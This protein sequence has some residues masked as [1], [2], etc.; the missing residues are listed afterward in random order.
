MTKITTKAFW[1]TSGN[2]GSRFLNFLATIYLA[3][4]LGTTN[5]GLISI[6]LSVLGYAVWISDMGLVKIGTRETAKPLEKREFTPSALFWIR[7]GA[8][9][10]VFLGGITLVTVLPLEG[11][12]PLVIGLFL[13]SVIPQSLFLDWYFTGLQKY[14]EVAI[15]KILKSAFFF[16]LV[17]LVIDVSQ[18]VGWV[19]LFY[20]AGSLT[21]TTYLFFRLQN[22]GSI[23]R[24]K[25]TRE[26]AVAAIRKSLTI[27]FGSS[28]NQVVQ[29]LPPIVIGA[30]ISAS[31]AGIYSAAIKVVL[32]GS[33]LDQV[34]VNLFLPMFTSYWSHNPDRAPA[35]ISRIFRIMLLLG[36]VFSAAFMTASEWIIPLL[37]G[38]EYTAS[39]P[40]LKVLSWFLAATFA[41]SVFAFGLLAINQDQAYFRSMLRGGLFGAAL[42]T[43]LTLIGAPIWTALAVLVSEIFIMSS[44][45][46]AI[47]STLKID[48]LQPALAGLA[49]I[50]ISAALYLFTQISLLL[51]LPLII[52]I[53]PLIY[54]ILGGIKQSDVTW[55][56]RLIQR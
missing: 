4:V 17:Y 9:I 12:R 31:D 7:F 18:D 54:F 42:I 2:T 56:I 8:G 24:F 19:P 15:G 10:L 14:R 44:N 51:Q 38:T 5:F 3:R 39:I 1:I 35:L 6:G 33:L 43:G 53:I 45:Y 21:A 47:R 52:G 36:L 23:F 30:F 34:F 26:T 49:C 41:N 27:G 37:F 55:L 29:L 46:I 16:L 40:I 13:F 50:L 20:L 22:P 25:L 11:N 28:F 48:I 32:I